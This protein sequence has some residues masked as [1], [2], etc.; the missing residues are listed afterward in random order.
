MRIRSVKRVTCADSR[1]GH[2]VLASDPAPISETRMFYGESWIVSV[3]ATQEGVRLDET[4][5]VLS[6]A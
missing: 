3:H 6:L 5:N 2:D 1:P 4:L